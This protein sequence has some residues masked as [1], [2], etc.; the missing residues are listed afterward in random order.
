MKPPI[1]WYAVG[2]WLVVITLLI[3]AII[4][5]VDA[6]A[7]E[8]EGVTYDPNT[9]YM[10]LMIRAAINGDQKTLDDAAMRRNAKIAGESMSWQPVSPAELIE[11]FE[12]RVGFSLSEDYMAKMITC[13]VAGDYTGGRNAATKRNIK[14]SF[15]GMS[16]EQITFDDFD[17]IARV[18][19]SEAGSYW[20]PM[21]WKMAVGEVVLNRV[22]SPEFPNTVHGVVYQPGQ[23]ASASYFAR[24]QPTQADTVAAARLANGERIFNHPAV[25]FQ[26]NFRQGSGVAAVF[27]DRYLGNTYFCYSSHMNLYA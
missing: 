8:Y 23:Y 9:D 17:L 10:E 7:A 13:S 1:D 6:R 3:I 21:N 11:T 26:A 5:T 20:L 24:M 27:T 25:V 2:Q 22:A 4:F 19:H 14:I 18:I 16:Y 12:E 15:L